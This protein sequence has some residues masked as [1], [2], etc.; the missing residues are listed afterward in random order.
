M[1]RMQQPDKEKLLI[2]NPK[3]PS[4]YTADNSVINLPQEKIYRI[5]GFW[6]GQSVKL[7][8]S[9]CFHVLKSSFEVNSLVAKTERVALS[10]I[11]TSVFPCLKGAHV[12]TAFSQ[13]AWGIW[14]KFEVPDTV[15][16]QFPA[17]VAIG[18]S[19]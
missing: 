6:A 17:K 12:I 14:N 19:S 2:L 7:T 18:F 11:W 10:E 3:A 15:F 4:S 13:S 5:F 8:R 9:T 16:L 1:T